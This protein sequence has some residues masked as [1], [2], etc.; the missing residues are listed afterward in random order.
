MR[1]PVRYGAMQKEIEEVRS[2]F[3]SEASILS[4]E[5]YVFGPAIIFLNGSVLAGPYLARLDIQ[6][7]D[8]EYM[9]LMYFVFCTII[10]T[11][12]GTARA[13]DNRGI[14]DVKIERGLPF[15]SCVC[16]ILVDASLWM[17]VLI[18]VGVSS[19][20]LTGE[21]L[22]R[23]SIIVLCGT[24]ANIGGITLGH[25]LIL[26]SVRANLARNIGALIIVAQALWYAT[27]ALIALGFGVLL[28]LNK[29]L[30]VRFE[31]I[32]YLLLGSLA[33]LVTLACLALYIACRSIGRKGVRF[34]KC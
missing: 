10:G 1:F 29:G 17:F 15:A 21:P 11:V 7:G 6:L 23:W 18:P 13:W 8:A 30:P 20:I 4:N 14:V 31:Q 19:S 26:F 28:P 27:P 16:P 22:T 5:W 25:L 32:A 3:L 24:I 12:S 9:C 33:F 34:Q 2:L